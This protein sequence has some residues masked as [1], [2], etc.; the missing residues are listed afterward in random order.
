MIEEMADD[1]FMPRSLAEL[2]DRPE[3]TDGRRNRLVMLVN[4]M[5]LGAVSPCLPESV[6]G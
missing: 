1:S 3:Q 6:A 4:I 2:N 5:G